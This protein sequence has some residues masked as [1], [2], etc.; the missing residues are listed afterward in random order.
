MSDSSSAQQ[1]PPGSSNLPARRLSTTELE[2]VIKRAVEL[3]AATGTPDE[4]IAEAE[5]VRIGQELGLDP[6]HVRRAVMDVRGRAPS[7]RG[8]MAA[9]MG[10][11][12][13]RAARTLKRPAAGLGLLLEEYLVRCEHMVVQR[14][15]PDR[16]RYVRD[17]SFAANM[18]RIVKKMTGKLRPMNLSQLDVAVSSIDADTALVEL[19]VEMKG[20]RAGFLA[21]GLAGGGGAAASIATV[22]WV[23]PAVDLLALVGV[24]VLLGA[25]WGMRGI[26]GATHR[27]V[28]DKLESFLD[29]LEHGDVKVPRDGS[30]WTAGFGGSGIGIWKG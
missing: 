13:A 1:P 20:A 6:V 4:G 17:T 29:A 16:T 28:H 11:G 24:P 10:P 23:T 8:A 14:R 3:Q 9:V 5:V 25:V 22:A 7:E 27:S 26:Y 21:G 30:S 2:A 18:S 19:S 12:V 15:F